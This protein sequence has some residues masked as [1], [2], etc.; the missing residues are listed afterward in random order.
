MKNDKPFKIFSSLFQP[1]FQLIPSS[2]YFVADREDVV[3]PGLAGYI[4]GINVGSR[5]E[6]CG[7]EGPASQAP[8]TVPSR[9]PGTFQFQA[10]PAASLGHAGPP[11]PRA[12]RLFTS[13]SRC[14]FLC[15][16]RNILIGRV[17]RGNLQVDGATLFVE[18]SQQ[19]AT[20][21]LMTAKVKAELRTEEDIVLC[22]AHGHKLAD[23]SGTTGISFWKQNARKTLAIENSQ[24]DELQRRRTSL[25]E[26]D[27]RKN[28][29]NLVQA[30]EELPAITQALRD[31]GQYARNRVATVALTEAQI[32][33]VKA[34]FKCIICRVD[35]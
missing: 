25:F 13:P 9:Q 31:L 19:E 28:V 16:E 22:D 32:A 1:L 33:S 15:L 29:E 21:P 24:Y 34:I 8:E 18:F 7:G 3:L 30:A 6:V 20:V 2:I 4:D 26:E 27:V 17:E 14:L 11:P 12:A 35:L 23:S 10:R 5:Y